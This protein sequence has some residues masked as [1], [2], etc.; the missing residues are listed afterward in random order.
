MRRAPY[1]SGFVRKTRA[2][3]FV[4]QVEQY[5]NKPSFGTISAGRCRI[6]TLRHERGMLDM[7]TEAE[8]IL[9][10]QIGEIRGADSGAMRDA[11]AYVQS[12]AAP[13]GS[14]GES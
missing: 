2:K 1:D 11:A 7:R 10:Q 3:L 14:P 8:D 13:P 6:W 12:L 5:F 4:F 9:F